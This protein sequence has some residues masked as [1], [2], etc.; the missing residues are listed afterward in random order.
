[1]RILL[2]LLLLVLL[3][4]GRMCARQ[5]RCVWLAVPVCPTRRW[6]MLR[7]EATRTAAVS[8]GVGWWG[9]IAAMPIVLLLRLLL[10]VRGRKMVSM[11][12]VG[13]VGLMMLLLAVG[14]VVSMLLLLLWRE[15]MVGRVSAMRH[16]YRPTCPCCCCCC[17]TW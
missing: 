5:Q 17:C 2:I 9:T 11:G 3:R 4:H 16:R 15:V 8:C 14:R 10:V 12:R 1:M 7:R 13:R 6:R